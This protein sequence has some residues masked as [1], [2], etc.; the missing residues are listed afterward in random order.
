LTRLSEGKTT[1][2][3]LVPVANELREFEMPRPMFTNRERTAWAGGLYDNRQAE[4]KTGRTLV[5]IIESPKSPQEVADARGQLAPFLR[6]TLVGLNYAYY[7]PPGAQMLHN[8]PLFVRYH[9]FAGLTIVSSDQAWHTPLLFGRGWAAGGG[10][11]LVG[12]LADLPYVLAQTEQDF[13]VPENVQAL[14][15]EDLVPSL[16]TSAVLPRWWRVSPTE[17]HAVTLYQRTGEE[18]LSAAAANADLRQRVLEMTFVPAPF[19][20]SWPKS[21]RQRRFT[22]QRNSEGASLARTP[23]GAPQARSWTLSLAVTPMRSVP[24]GLLKTLVFLTPP[25][26]KL[27]LANC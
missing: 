27:M 25:W 20:R 24:N 26:R 8:N 21:L 5:Q 4:L 15:W 14:V 7:E 17:L 6:D 10:A 23:I 9:D 13:I 12:S 2:E 11:H 3:A 19:S 1:A 18:L 16:L 22:S